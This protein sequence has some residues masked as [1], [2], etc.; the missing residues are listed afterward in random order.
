M[1]QEFQDV[2][3]A[4]QCLLAMSHSRDYL[5]CN[6]PLDLSS[7]PYS[8][9]EYESRIVPENQTPAVIVE[10]IPAIYSQQEVHP[11]TTNAATES[12]SYMVARILTDLTSIKQEPVPEV[13]SEHEDPLTID[14]ADS[15]FE[16]SPN[17]SVEDV[18]SIVKT[19]QPDTV[20]MPAVSVITS[21]TTTIPTSVAVVSPKN[22]PAKSRKHSRK[23]AT[24][25]SNQT[26]TT[27]P[28]TTGKTAASQMRKTH[29]CSYDGCHKVYGKSSHLKAHL[30]THTG[31]CMT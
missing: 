9:G 18:T 4:A 19:E 26:T 1:D 30:R 17:N 16:Y 24:P 12:S 23:S 6:R 22:S 21:T 10:N 11:V 31:Q 5:M 15:A 8:R 3:F 2:N 14:E 25:K 20:E 7:R 28:P 13:P 29:K 27:T